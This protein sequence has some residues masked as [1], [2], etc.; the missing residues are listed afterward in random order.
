M[1]RSN[2][3]GPGRGPRAP[4][5]SDVDALDGRLVAVW[6]DNRTDDDYSVQLPIGNKVVAGRAYSSG[7]DV[8]GTYAATSTDGVSWRTL[9][10]VSTRTSSGPWSA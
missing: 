2:G 10:T 7:H 9:G 5:L 4:V 1:I 8:T 3:A 6:Q